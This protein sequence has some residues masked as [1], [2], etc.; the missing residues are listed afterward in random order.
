[1]MALFIASISTYAQSEGDKILGGW[2]SEN[3]DG[4]IEVYKSGEKYYGKLVWGKTMYEAD[5][6]TSRKDEKNDDEKLRGRNLKD[7]VIL[8]DFTYDDGQYKSGKIYDPQSGNTY[9]CNMKIKDDKLA[10][11]GYVGISLFGRSSSWTRTQ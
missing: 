8:T 6:K 5:G 2:L 3:K 10:I 7:L 1:M 4:K 11:R 9:S